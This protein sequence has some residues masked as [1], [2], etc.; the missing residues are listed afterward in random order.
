MYSMYIPKI[1]CTQKYTQ[2]TYQKLWFLNS[3]VHRIDKHI[4]L[5]GR[6]L[7][8]KPFKAMSAVF[9]I[10]YF[11]RIRSTVNYLLFIFL[12]LCPNYHQ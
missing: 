12:Y 7:S 11:L 3:D 5:E 6:H 4:T 8:E 9:Q 2:C 1:K 10:K